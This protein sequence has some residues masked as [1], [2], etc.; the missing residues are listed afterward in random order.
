MAIDPSISLNVRPPVIAPLQI[1]NPLDQVAKLQSLR[2]LMQQG[3]SGQLSLQEQQ[4]KLDEA[5]Q[6]MQERADLAKVIAAAQAPAH[7]AGAAAPTM[8]PVQPT[9]PGGTAPQ[10][11]P[12]LPAPGAPGAPLGTLAAATAPAVPQTQIAPNFGLAPTPAAG[13]PQDAAAQQ[14]PLIGGMSYGDFLARFPRLGPGMLKT[15][16]ELDKAQTEADV[17]HNDAQ[18]QRWEAMAGAAQAVSAAKNPQQEYRNQV[19]GLQTAGYITPPEART[20][21]DHGFDPDVLKGWKDRAISQTDFHNAQKT[22]AETQVKDRENFALA[23]T[24]VNDQ[25]GYDKVFSQLPSRLQAE[26]GSKFSPELK[27]ATSTWN[28]PRADV[29]KV[30]M[31]QL[32]LDAVRLA[33]AR[34]QGQGV[35]DQ[36]LT[37]IGAKRAAPFMGADT[38]LEVMKRAQDPEKYVTSAQAADQT[39]LADLEIGGK[40]HKV[41]VNKRT[42]EVVKDLGESGIKPPQVNVNAGASLL[43]RESARF[44][45]PHE[46]SV[47]DA[48]SQLEKI[49]EARA[50]INGPATAQALGIPKVLIAI[51]GGQGSGLKVNQAELNSIGKARG[52]EGDVEGFLRKVSGQG[53][54]TQEQQRQLTGLLDDVSAR[55]VQKQAIANDALDRINSAGSRDEIVKIDKEARQKL[56]TTAAQPAKPASGP[57]KEGDTRVINGTTYT[58]DAKGNWK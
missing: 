54:L 21:L 26:V 8:P 58:R 2:N 32:Q 42:G 45:K 15:H 4:L 38:P 43:D 40:P 44:A 39:D 46:K 37:E 29:P 53:T 24:N 52:I 50:L 25:A 48:N 12:A 47:A 17:K 35:Y 19:F 23:M 16:I 1:A 30:Q 10:I 49:N 6:E 31:A 57:Y 34:A 27:D 13:P 9:P 33:A 7:A 20:F 11:A 41:L 51:A 22:D 3:Q 56:G 55:M 14:G 5:R 28:V 18:K 36:A